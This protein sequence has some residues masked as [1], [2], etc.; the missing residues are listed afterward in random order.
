MQYSPASTA[1]YSSASAARN[2]LGELYLADKSYP[3]AIAALDEA[4]RLA[5]RWWPPYRNLAMAKLASQDDAGALA[6]YE[7]GVRATGEP[8]LVVEPVVVP[9][10]F[11]V[12]PVPLVV[13]PVEVPVDPP[14]NACRI[15]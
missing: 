12:V 7:A 10:P 11:G 3:L 2:L 1:W 14:S 8:V 13:L 9:E 15:S 6:V 4:V 5:P